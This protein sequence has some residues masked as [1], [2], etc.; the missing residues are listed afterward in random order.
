MREGLKPVEWM[1]DRVNE[2]RVHTEGEY[3]VLYVARFQRA[4][5]V[6]HAFAKRAQK[7]PRA[8]ISLAR[9]RYKEVLRMEGLKR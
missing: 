6:L 8:A 5:Y 1:G 9:A 3:R 2:I 7:T 4:I